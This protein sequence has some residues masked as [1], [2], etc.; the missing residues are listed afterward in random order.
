MSWLWK[1]HLAE[2]TG[3]L[4]YFRTHETQALGI[5]D[6]AA[7]SSCTGIWLERKKVKKK[8]GEGL[9]SSARAV[10]HSILLATC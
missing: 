5:L 6:I 7:G 2:R 9:M 3:F 10:L 1:E 4:H 8:E